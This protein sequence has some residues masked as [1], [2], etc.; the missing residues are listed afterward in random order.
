VEENIRTI[1]PCRAGGLQE[2]ECPQ[3]VRIKEVTWSEYRHVHVTLCCQ[4][5]YC[6]RRVALE[7]GADGRGIP[8]V[9]A[10][11]AI[12]ACARAFLCIRE[13]FQVAGICQGIKIHDLSREAG[14]SEEVEYEI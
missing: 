14:G 8:N 5:N 10:L 3:N 4:V 13:A 2:I 9:N 11:E 1:L 6:I 12:P 7:N